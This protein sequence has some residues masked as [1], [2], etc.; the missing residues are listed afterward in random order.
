M[1]LRGQLCKPKNAKKRAW[2]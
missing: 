1:T 2:K